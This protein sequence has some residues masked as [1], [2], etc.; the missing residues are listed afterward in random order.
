MGQHCAEAHA[1]TALPARRSIFPSS[2]LYPAFLA[3]TGGRTGQCSAHPSVA[4]E[5]YEV[6]HVEEGSLGAA[7]SLWKRRGA[8]PG[9]VGELHRLGE[10]GAVNGKRA[11]RSWKCAPSINPSTKCLDHSRA[12]PRPVRVT[13]TLRRTSSATRSGNFTLLPSSS[14]LIHSSSGTFVSPHAT[15]V[16][17]SGS[18]Y[19]NMVCRSCLHRGLTRRLPCTRQN[20]KRMRLQPSPQSLPARSAHR[21]VHVLFPG[22]FDHARLRHFF[23]DAGE[24]CFAGFFLSFILRHIPIMVQARSNKVQFS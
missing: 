13:S 23:L 22:G 10:C 24:Y 8:A 21:L 19:P 9:K 16:F 17:C 1:D 6:A 12:A 2:R 11:D 7:E 15:P 4:Q 20:M 5:P 18:P 3:Q 14:V